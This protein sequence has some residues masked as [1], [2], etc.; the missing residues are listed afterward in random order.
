[1]SAGFGLYVVATLL[2][3][4][5]PGPKVL[6]MVSLGLRAGPAAVFRGVGQTTPAAKH[7]CISCRSGCRRPSSTPR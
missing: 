4:L 3:S 1:M 6:L 5:S 2:L 7:L